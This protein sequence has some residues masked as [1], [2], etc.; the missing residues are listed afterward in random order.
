MTVARVVLSFL[1]VA[2]LVLSSQTARAQGTIFAPGWT[3]QPDAST[4]RFQS[5]KNLTKVESSGFAQFQGKIDP[6]GAAEI[7][8][9]LDSV[10]TKI[11][12]RNVRMRF[13][14]F[15]TFEFPEAVVSTRIEAAALADLAKLRRKIIPLTF[16]LQLHGV[17]RSLE[18][19]VAVTLVGE[20][21]VAVSST[22]PLSIATSDF[23]LDGG[24]KK[25]EEA[26][27]VAIVPSATVTFDFLFSKNAD[28]QVVADVQPQVTQAAA[29]AIEPEGNLDDEACEGRF[30]ILSR[31]DNIYFASGSARLDARSA[32]LLDSL[33]DI[34]VRCPD[35]NIEVGGHTDSD[36]GA[37]GNQRLSERRAAAVEDYIAAQN[38]SALRITSVG[39]GETR[40]VASNDT[41]DGKRRNRR[42]EFTVVE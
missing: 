9:F 13:L 18:T 16:D 5:V 29:T 21:I 12:L 40:P 32:P 10:D 2:C 20:D 25:L 28:A 3:L 15:E 31:T 33:V 24:V 1:C 41:P 22:E 39:Y 38:V 19:E 11:D 23:N 27:N 8:I 42:I 17:I 36:G 7:R 34:I 4:V 26:A 37:A 14:F 30:E 35:L 6:D